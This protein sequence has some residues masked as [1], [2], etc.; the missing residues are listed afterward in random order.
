MFRQVHI[1]CHANN[2]SAVP[3]ATTDAPVLLATFGSSQCIRVFQLTYEDAPVIQ[4][5]ITMSFI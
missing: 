5:S 2:S 1:L 3:I 4:V